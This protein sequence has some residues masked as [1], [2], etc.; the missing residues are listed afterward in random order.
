MRN[1]FTI[2]TATRPRRPYKVHWFIRAFQCWMWVTGG[3][4]G[5]LL[6]AI[7]INVISPGHPVF[8]VVREWCEAARD[9][10]F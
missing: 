2:Q 1:E 4:S 5:V 3:L 6:A 7:I 8:L 9:L 10:F